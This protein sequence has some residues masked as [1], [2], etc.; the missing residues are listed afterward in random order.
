MGYRG[1][2][3]VQVQC[4]VCQL[5]DIACLRFLVKAKLPD[6]AQCRRPCTEDERAA[7]LIESMAANGCESIV[8]VNARIEIS[9]KPPSSPITLI[10]V[11]W[12]VFYRNSSLVTQPKLQ[13]ECPFPAVVRMH[14]VYPSYKS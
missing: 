8:P 5:D 14:H 1:T 11:S 7:G 13:C 9:L 6:R 2:T 12:R 4:K 10:S 3:K